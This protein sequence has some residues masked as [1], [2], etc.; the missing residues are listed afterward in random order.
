M[1]IV[2]LVLLA[3]PDMP[4]SAN[5]LVAKMKAE[6]GKYSYGSA[7]IGTTTHLAGEMLKL[8]AGLDVVHVPYRGLDRRFKTPR[9]V[10]SPFSL[11]RLRR[12]SRC[13]RPGS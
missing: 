6:P 2:P 8:R 1:G 3:S 13:T 11:R 5:A 9:R 4:A 10:E 7:G 12:Q